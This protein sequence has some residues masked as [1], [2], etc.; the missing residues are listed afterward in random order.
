MLRRNFLAGGTAAVAVLAAGH[1]R[2]A[3]AASSNAT[4]IRFGFLNSRASALGA[5]GVAFAKEVEK[6]CG[7]RI[8]IELYPAGEAGGE[9]EMV[10]DVPARW[11]WSM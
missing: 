3:A 8:R 5:G 10:Q 7:S 6:T 2:T 4:V 9:V 11:T 1:R